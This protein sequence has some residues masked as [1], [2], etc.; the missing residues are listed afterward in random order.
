MP[1]WLSPDTERAAAMLEAH[2]DYRILRSLPPLD[3]LPLPVAEGRLRTAAILDTETTS[4]D[5]AT[6]RGRKDGK[7]L[8]AAAP[9][10]ELVAPRPIELDDVPHV[11]APLGRMVVRE[12]EVWSVSS[13]DLVVRLWS[14]DACV[15]R[16]S[17][18]L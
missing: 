6:G 12:N 7:P 15:L 11:A 10:E 17:Y 14:V 2:P 3:L 5:P 4:L 13:D 1:Q 16:H 9:N 18:V 8:V